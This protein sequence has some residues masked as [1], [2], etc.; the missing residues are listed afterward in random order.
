MPILDLR[1]DHR[2]E[3]PGDAEFSTYFDVF[4]ALNLNNVVG[5]GSR[6]DSFGAVVGICPR[7]WRGWECACGSEGRTAGPLTRISVSRR[8]AERRC[9]G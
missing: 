2:L 5:E 3:L 4:N 8:G 6:D 9:A 7:G 1:L